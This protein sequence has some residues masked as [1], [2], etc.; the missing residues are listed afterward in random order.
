MN[1]YL[2]LVVLLALGLVI[3]ACTTEVEV[4]RE[5]EVTREV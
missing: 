1:K 2:V 3:A 4:V 5:V